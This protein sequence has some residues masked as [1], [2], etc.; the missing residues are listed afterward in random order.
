ML[1]A[2]SLPDAAIGL[3][4]AAN[5]PQFAEATK[6]NP[7]VPSFCIDIE[8]KSKYFVILFCSGNNNGLCL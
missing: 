3:D 5:E 1:E 6:A 8:S 7:N 4:P 2:G